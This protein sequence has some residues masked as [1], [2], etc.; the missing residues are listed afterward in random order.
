M[1]ANRPRST[2]EVPRRHK[3]TS[4]E[5]PKPGPIHDHAPALSDADFDTSKYA[6]GDYVQNDYAQNDYSRAE[7]I[8]Q[9]EASPDYNRTPYAQP[10]A[11]AP[12]PVMTPAEARRAD[13]NSWRNDASSTGLTPTDP[14]RDDLT[15]LRYRS[16]SKSSALDPSSRFKNR[17]K[18][19]DSLSGTPPLS[20]RPSTPDNLSSGHQP[21]QT[22]Q[23]AFE[24]LT[25]DPVTGQPMRIVALIFGFLILAGI[26]TAI[27]G[28]FFWTGLV[29]LS[30]M[31]FN[32]LGDDAALGGM[33]SK[34]KSFFG[35]FHPALATTMGLRI[36]VIAVGLLSLLM[37]FRF[38]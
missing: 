33:V 35:N 24:D 12:A 7:Y 4:L 10:S 36:L 30:I 25:S 17:T 34:L 15:T 20:T 14:L 5:A 16:K 28:N 11:P 26:G 8:P 13:P 2:L 18:T 1:D 3:G 31:T 29:V 21:P 32:N 6:R 37:V 9:T 22:W 27:L 23:Q 19:L 38:T